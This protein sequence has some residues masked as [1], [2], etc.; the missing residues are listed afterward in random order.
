MWTA[1]FWIPWKSGKMRERATCG[2]KVPEENLS[3]I[4]YPMTMAEGAAYV[5]ERYCLTVPLDVIIQ[6]VLDAV[7]DFYF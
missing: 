7:R 3:E 6:G 1:R 2:G 5:K 4:L